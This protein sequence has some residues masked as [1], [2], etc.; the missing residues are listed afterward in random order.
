VCR[1]PLLPLTTNGKDQAD[2]G[3][4]QRWNGHEDYQQGGVLGPRGVDKEWWLRQHHEQDDGQTNEG[5]D[6]QACQNSEESHRS[7][8]AQIVVAIVALR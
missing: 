8:L 3:A 2:K 7:N 1:R 4:D 5:A 6:H